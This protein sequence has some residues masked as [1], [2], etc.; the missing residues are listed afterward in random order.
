LQLDTV[1]E[2]VDELSNQTN[3]S[4][5]ESEDTEIALGILT[6]DVDPALYLWAIIVEQVQLS[7]QNEGE[8]ESE[9]A[10]PMLKLDMSWQEN[11][12]ENARVG[13][14]TIHQCDFDF[15]IEEDG[16]GA[17]EDNV[18][19]TGFTVDKE[20][21]LKFTFWKKRLRD[22]REL[23]KADA[24]AKLKAKCPTLFAMGWFKEN[25]PKDKGALEKED[26]E[27]KEESI[28][29]ASNKQ[30]ELTVNIRPNIWKSSV[31]KKTDF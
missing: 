17:T 9:S 31:K 29:W 5:D 11:L 16:G 27:L 8:F 18:V 23:L 10:P 28:E 25:L 24:L 26:E 19:V 15:D 2:A 22:V 14:T 20:D 4:G 21:P 30:N 13:I 6:A 3:D 1:L 7:D 12:L